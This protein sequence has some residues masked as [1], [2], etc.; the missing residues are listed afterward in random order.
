[1]KK[2]LISLLIL[3]IILGCGYHFKGGGYLKSSDISNIYIKLFENNTEVRGLENTLTNALVYEYNVD[4]ETSVTGEKEAQAILAGEIISYEV[5][6]VAYGRGDY[7]AAG[8]IVL[9]IR[10]K[11]KRKGADVVW[12]NELTDQEEYMVSN[13]L[14]QTEKYRNEALR[15]IIQ[16]MAE[17]IHDQI[18]L[19]F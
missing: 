19:G 11:L 12:K 14:T 7:T 15:R 18:S 9:K 1:M 5:Y 6:T 10:A 3:I 17:R 2:N 4:K 8:R 16:R 13:D